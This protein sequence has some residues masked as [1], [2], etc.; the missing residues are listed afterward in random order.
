MI[1]TPG[2]LLFNKLLPDQ[3]R[4]DA[5]DRP[6]DAGRIKEIL[7]RVA[8]ETPDRYRDVSHDILKFGA[9]ASNEVSA[10]FSLED[11]KPPVDKVK[12]I[13]EIR[14]AE[15]QINARKDLTPAQK[16][17]ERVKIYGKYS[18]EFPESVFNAAY[19]K[20][21]NLAKMVASGARGSKGQL[22]SNI[23][24]DFLM[25]DA[26]SNPIPVP[27]LSSYSE[28]LS[29][30]EFFASAYGTRRGLLSTKLS[31]AESGYLCLNGGTMVRMAD[32]SIKPIEEVKVGDMVL[33][34]D[35]NGNTF[36]T[37]VNNVF[38]NGA[39]EVWRY[40][41]RYGKSR[42]QFEYIEATPDH[43]VLSKIK[44][45]LKRKSSIFVPTKLPLSRVQG[46][47]RLV[48]AGQ[49]QD[50]R[51]RREPLAFVLGYLLGDGG[52]TG[53]SVNFSTADPAIVNRISSDLSAFGY[54]VKK[55][56][57]RAADYEYTIQEI[58]QSH[59][60]RADRERNGK[61][62]SKRTWL[63][64]RLVDLKMWGKY[65][66][67]KT[68]PE[69]VSAW[70]QRSVQE[71]IAGLLSSDGGVEKSN[72]TPVPVVNFGVTSFALTKGVHDL[73]RFRM[74]VFPSS[75]F[76]T[77]TAGK[78]PSK[79]S[80][81]KNGANFDI[82][83]FSISDKNSIQRLFD[84]VA[85]VGEK[86]LYFQELML[87]IHNARRANGDFV[88]SYIDKE[89]MGLSETYDIEVDHPDHLFVLANGMVVSNSK[90]L[91]AA[92][93]DLVVT[94]KDCETSRGI[95]TTPDDKDNIGSV[96]ASPV[97]G[98][99]AGTVVTG[100]VLKQ[101]RDSGAKALTVRSP[102]TCGAHRGVCSRCAGI[103]EKNR[104]PQIM[105]TIGLAGASS[106]GEPLSQGTLCLWDK[107]LVRMADW[108]VKEIRSI[109]VGEWVLG[110]D[111][112]GN[113][114]PV[115]VVNVFDRGV[116]ECIET[117]FKTGIK[118]SISMVSTSEHKILCKW[119]KSGCEG[120]KLNHTLQVLPVGT[121]CHSF[122]AILAESFDDN[123]LINEPWA[124]FVGVVL[125]DGCCT[126]SVH[127]VHLSCADDMQIEALQPY[128]RIFNLK[129]SKL[130]GHDCYW[131]FSQITEV[132]AERNDMG[133]FGGSFRNPAQLAVRRF[134]I[135]G[136]YA[137][138]KE[139]PDE[140]YS[141]SNKS[142]AELL[143][144]LF[145]TDGSVYLRR[146]HGQEWIGFSFTSA[147][148]KMCHQVREL[149]QWR[150]G[151]Y[152]T[153][154]TNK[155]SKKKPRGSFDI[156]IATND[157]ARKFY[158]SIPMIGIKASKMAGW[159]SLLESN[160]VLRW[161]RAS[162]SKVVA[163]GSL[164]TMDIEVDHPDHLFVLENGMIV[165]NS[166]K[167][168]GGVASSSGK[169][170]SA[171]KQIDSLVQVPEVF[172]NAATI[173]QTDGR[174]GSI[175]AAP[176]GGSYVVIGDKRHYIPRGRDIFV[177]KG[178]TIEAGDVLSGGVPNPA[179]IV[180]HKGIGAGRLYFVNAMRKAMQDNKI[181]VDRRNLEVLG[182][183]LVDHVKITNPDGY[184]GFLPDD[185][186][187]YGAIEENFHP[188]N[189]TPLQPAKAVGKYLAKPVMHFTIGTRITPSV[190]KTL[191]DAGESSIDT[192]DDSPGFEP[193]MQRVA[194]IPGFK[195]DWQARFAGSNIK[196]HLARAVQS[197]DAVSDI[198]GTS[199]I[200]GLAK[201]TEFGRPPP[202]TIAY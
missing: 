162:R 71:L 41:F 195:P 14:L 70:D 133:Q 20:G 16:I 95:P 47:F 99:P 138:E 129:L 117:H 86:R 132:A 108:S 136:K 87:N 57:K 155:P 169:A 79:N 89:P 110:A 185:V 147:S 19:A 126:D 44:G 166:E 64:Q 137:H 100:R 28:G 171:F 50:E 199:Y 25:L 160:R 15:K 150:F 53:R 123:G 62:K 78:G 63:I 135:H 143:A 77:K 184:G 148:E 181:D 96:L 35:I 158:D 30:G 36:P 26:N 113:T 56:R 88:Y 24:A 196:K 27:I 116:Q 124:L 84:T 146:Q 40:K 105:E 90:Q 29:P 83:S 45:G 114:F 54:R 186:V 139:I 33:G 61:V 8:E 164:H 141:W 67:E 159:R 174:V 38:K 21:S 69:E 154:H 183:S 102:L 122:S 46:N 4:D 168:S 175:E 128:L 3:I 104:F 7:Q 134:G 98:I 127:G 82:F 101:I 34:S 55:V 201:G 200:P 173:A 191:T 11:L 106:V 80:L 66:Q 68:V 149:L 48:P 10:S 92:A 176:Q 197:G 81:A 93:H 51:G 22:N 115:Q 9:T 18:S 2:R 120:E 43:K 59:L 157:S 60:Y 121:R 172:P 182:R 188:E 167:H 194:D 65:A 163:A 109:N 170:V 119:L 76:R 179:D 107:T 13:A 187:E 118:T 39:K 193:D 130:K 23:G 58:A 72:N 112:D 97:A 42:T 189:V 91:A 178:D 152:S 153:F 177:K 165:S 32:W 111:K 52:L 31:V 180:R 49:F 145:V 161:K 202:G 192:I 151:I 73:L 156:K 144:G 5:D 1:L 37:L 103:R 12:V 75:I 190:S 74:G 17:S 6:V 131:R 142:V 125:G 140:V 94:S 85:M 198:H